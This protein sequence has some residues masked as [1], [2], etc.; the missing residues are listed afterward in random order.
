MKVLIVLAHPETRS[1]N[2][3]LSRATEEVLCGQGHEVELSDLCRMSFAPDEHERHFVQR[4]DPSRFDA[5]TEQRFNTERETL[6]A[7]V[8]KEIDKILWSDV[9]IF[10]FPLWWFGMP[11]ILKGWMDRVFAYGALYKGNQRLHTGI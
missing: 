8:R 11:A 10:Q 7:D 2:A 3:E 5:Q 1:F 4:K 6:P 9:M